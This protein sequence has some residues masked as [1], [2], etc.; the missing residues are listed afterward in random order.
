MFYQLPPVGNPIR[1]H[2]QADASDLSLAVSYQRQFYASGTAALAAA[3]I[4]AIKQ[5]DKN[6]PEIILP[7]YGCPDLISAVVYAGAKPVLVDLEIDRPWLGLSQLS[8]AITENTAAIIAVDLFGIPE[9]WSQLREVIAQR[10]IV[11]IEDSAQYFPADDVQQDWQ[12]DMV[13]LSFGRGK[14]VSLL[15]GGAV[16]TKSSVLYEHLPKH[17]GNASGFIQRRSFSLKARLYNAMISPLVYWLPQALPFLHLGETRY[18]KLPGI[19]AMDQVR[20]DLLK[21]NISAYQDDARAIARCDDISSMLDSLGKIHNLPRL[22]E[23]TITR[24]LLRYPLLLDETTRDRVYQ[25]LKQ[26]GLGVSIMYPAS[27]PNITGLQGVI[28]DRQNFPNAEMF[29]SRLLTLPTHSHV[30]DKDIE[31]MN[32]MLKQIVI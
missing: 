27:L 12:G 7:A 21:G 15:G 2:A 30:S 31:K 11:L 19:E 29:A 26:A 3:V 10:N 17:P 4:A 32:T 14:P 13:V 6:A 8:S 28:D 9:R 20:L 22:C 16:L 5:T 24:R 25:K 18:H 23:L 1:L